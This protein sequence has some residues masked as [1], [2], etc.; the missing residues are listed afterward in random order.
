MIPFFCNIREMIRMKERQSKKNEICV[1]KRREL[2]M[3]HIHSQCCVFLQ[4]CI[5]GHIKSKN[6][7]SKDR[8][9]KREKKKEIFKCI[10]LGQKFQNLPLRFIELFSTSRYKTIS[11]LSFFP[12]FSFLKDDST[13][14]YSSMYFTFK[15]FF[16]SFFF[17]L[18]LRSKISCNL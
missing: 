11:L 13:L 9:L 1:W 7:L 10:K 6:K 15:F 5:N 2:K 12:F 14:R 17:L 4:W 18:L 3:A 16:L 8:R